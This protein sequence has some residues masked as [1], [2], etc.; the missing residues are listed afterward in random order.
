[1]VTS[2]PRATSSH[3]E[4]NIHSPAQKLAMQ[5]ADQ[6][7]CLSLTLKTHNKL[8]HMLLPE[9]APHAEHPCWIPVRPHFAELVH[10]FNA[11]LMRQL[12]ALMQ[13]LDAMQALMTQ[14]EQGEAAGERDAPVQT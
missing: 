12:D 2:P 3:D 4:L 14:K 1:M 5:A 8:G 7:Y 9:R 13:T 11:E 10:T 6:A